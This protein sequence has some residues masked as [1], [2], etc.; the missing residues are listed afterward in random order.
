MQRVGIWAKASGLPPIWVTLLCEEEECSSES[1]ALPLLTGSD[2]S[3][4]RMTCW[5][6]SLLEH[7]QAIACPKL[8]E[9]SGFLTLR[10]P[11]FGLRLAGEHEV[12]SICT[13][14]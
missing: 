6:K 9:S 12:H 8:N 7:P 2:P 1:C 11:D 13:Q 5:I 10:R 4:P 14:P 3:S